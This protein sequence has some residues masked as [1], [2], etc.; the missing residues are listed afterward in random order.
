MNPS[1]KIEIYVSGFR[2]LDWH[3]GHIPSE[4]LFNLRKSQSSTSIAREI[5]GMHGFH[6][7][8]YL[9]C[10]SHNPCFRC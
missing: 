6:E 10:E 2:P 8:F 9:N 1:T 5:K 3:I 4:N 7:A